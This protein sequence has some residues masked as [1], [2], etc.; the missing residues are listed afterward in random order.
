MKA[1]I[2][3]LEHHPFTRESRHMWCLDCA[4]V[5]CVAVR[6]LC[7]R[8][9][10]LVDTHVI[11]EEQNEIGGWCSLNEQV[12]EA[13]LEGTFSADDAACLTLI[14]AVIQ[15][16]CSEIVLLGC[17]LLS[18]IVCGV[19]SMDCG[20]RQSSIPSVSSHSPSSRFTHA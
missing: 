8:H 1:T 6:A 18:C 5:A 7:Q 15:L 12:S 9:L 16:R 11:N 13:R 2:P 20:F 10:D 17:G 4:V 19:S 3:S 14:G